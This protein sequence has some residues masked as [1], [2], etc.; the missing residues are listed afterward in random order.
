[1]TLTEM[2][3]TNCNKLLAKIAGTAEIVCPRCKTMNKGETP[4]VHN[5]KA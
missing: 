1:M 2:R 5:E 4:D 3:C